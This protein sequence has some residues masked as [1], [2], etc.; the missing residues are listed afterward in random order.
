MVPEPENKAEGEVE[1]VADDYVVE[2]AG[3]RFDVTVHG[4]ATAAPVAQ[5]G[6][7]KAAPKRERKSSRGGSGRHLASPMQGNVFKALVE[8]G[9]SVGEG[10]LS[11]SSRR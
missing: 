11:E 4:E 9:A 2:V 3:K 1:I 10:A 6:A 8:K 7:P 5:N